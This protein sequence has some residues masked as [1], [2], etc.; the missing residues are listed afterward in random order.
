MNILTF[1]KNNGSFVLKSFSSKGNRFSGELDRKLCGLYL[2]VDQLK[3][4][5]TK[6][7]FNVYFLIYLKYIKRLKDKQ[8]NLLPLNLLLKTNKDI[9]YIQIYYTNFNFSFNNCSSFY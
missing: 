9:S 1:L 7:K 3:I 5:N 6:K 4:P 2:L 8:I